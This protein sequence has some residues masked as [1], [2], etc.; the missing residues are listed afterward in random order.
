MSLTNNLF[1]F[2][3]NPNLVS[4][5]EIDSGYSLSPNIYCHL[6][7]YEYQMSALKDIRDVFGALFIVVTCYVFV[8]ERYV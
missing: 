4:Y 6:N 8:C 3:E 5:T 2:I 1:C 7:E